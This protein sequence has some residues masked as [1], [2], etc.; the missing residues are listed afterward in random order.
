[1]FQVIGERIEKDIRDIY[2]DSMECCVDEWDIGDNV[3]NF[4]KNEF[5]C[6]K[7]A[8]DYTIAG[9]E[10]GNFNELGAMSILNYAV[11]SKEQTYLYFQEVKNEFEGMEEIAGRYK[12]V[13]DI[14]QGIQE[15][16]PRIIR[17]DSKI[18]RTRIPSLINYLKEAKCEE[19][20]AAESLKLF[21]RETL[22]NRHIDFYDV[23]KFI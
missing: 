10:E 18:D 17:L 19:E 11:I 20:K 16:I 1:M 3:S 12:N 9:L 8:Y 15:I 4:S 22:Y 23:K 21:L 14:F 5:G 6:G 2:L 7:R 13:S